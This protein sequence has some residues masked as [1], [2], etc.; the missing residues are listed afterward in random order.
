MITCCQCEAIERQFGSRIA[1]RELR[2]FRRRGP[3]PSTQMLITGLADFVARGPSAA[4]L[5]IGGGIGAIH[6]ALLDAGVSEATQVDV[7]AEYLNAARREAARRDHA[8]RVQ[9]IHG[10]FVQLAPDLPSADVVTLDR[11]ICCYPDMDQLV[12]R[13]AEKARHVLG[14]V[15]PRNVWWVRLG[16]ALTNRVTQ[17]RRCAF[18]VFVHEPMAIDATLRAHGLERAVLRRTF[19]WEVAVYRRINA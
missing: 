17:L 3:I 18:R 4:L 10:D 8:G 12:I 16:V 6:H 13:A 2:R 14:A 19:V 15:Y 5:D 1:E 9:F 11:V 7:S